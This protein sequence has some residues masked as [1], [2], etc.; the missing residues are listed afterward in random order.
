M[1]C[2][3]SRG[4][5][6]EAIYFFIKRH[7]SS[8]CAC[9]PVLAMALRYPGRALAVSCSDTGSPPRPR[10]SMLCLRLHL[11]VLLAAA[12]APGL[13]HP[14]H[15]AQPTRPRVLGVSRCPSSPGTQRDANRTTAERGAETSESQTAKPQPSQSEPSERARRRPS[16]RTRGCCP[17]SSRCSSRGPSGPASSRT[18]E[19]R[20][21]RVQRLY[22]SS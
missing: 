16:A 10:L 11:L 14:L 22:V 4:R 19:V 17:R 5:G 3:T 6:A 9:R 18:K 7:R 21:L 8:A 13:S 15:A 12:A 1:H 2:I 20:L